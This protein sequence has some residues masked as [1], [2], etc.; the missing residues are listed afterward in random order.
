MTTTKPITNLGF[1]CFYVL[2]ERTIPQFPTSSVSGPSSFV[3]IPRMLEGPLPGENKAFLP[4][5]IKRKMWE[6]VVVP[7]LNLDKWEALGIKGK[8]RIRTKRSEREIIR[9]IDQE[10]EKKKKEEGFLPDDY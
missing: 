1:A 10:L 2:T 9:L 6:Q 8:K 5:R 7:V 4:L 3:Y